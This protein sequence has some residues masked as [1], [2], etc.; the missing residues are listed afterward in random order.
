MGNKFIGRI[1]IVLFTILLILTV[2]LGLV[3]NLI[4]DKKAVVTNSL[5]PKDSPKRMMLIFPHPDDEITV[6]GEVFREI[7]EENAKVT[8]VV[9][10]EGEAGKT[11]GV[12][13]KNE[14]GKAREKEGMQAAKTLGVT[15]V[16]A[17]FPDGK[18]S[19]VNP[20]ELKNYIYQQIKKYKPTT[21]L[22]YDDDVGYYGHPDHIFAAKMVREV[23]RE[24]MDD[25][26]F[27]A[28]RLYMVTLPSRVWDSVSKFGKKLR[29]KYPLKE[30][31]RPPTPTNAVLVKD[32]G[33]QIDVLA[34]GYKTQQQAVDALLPG[35][36]Q[37][38][39]WIYFRVLDREYF[40]LAEEKK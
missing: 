39:Y 33:K 37:I 32:Y 19:E 13:S 14:L 25:S 40:Y 18:L 16:Q 10:T 22:T 9:L 6:S 29:E 27:S 8:L 24:H 38:P 12:V 28:K 2:G 4:L 35:H 36:R 21:I 17:T 34:K 1:L 3:H 5:I 7:H 11:G 20:I 23:F 15:P 26:S 31:Q 30:N